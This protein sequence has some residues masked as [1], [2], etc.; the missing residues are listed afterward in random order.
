MIGFLQLGLVGKPGAGHIVASNDGKAANIREADLSEAS[1]IIY[2]ES[3]NQLIF[4]GRR[5]P[6]L[7]RTAMIIYCWLDVHIP[8]PAWFEY[9]TPR[10][11]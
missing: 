5:I 3:S 10:G 11:I 6:H 9:T 1:E 2:I 7:R 4:C 8:F